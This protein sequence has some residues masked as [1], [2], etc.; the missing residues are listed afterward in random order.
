M[1]KWSTILFVL[2]LILTIGAAGPK[3]PK[4]KSMEKSTSTWNWA[5]ASWWI[6][7]EE[8]DAWAHFE[9]TAQGFWLS[10]YIERGYAVEEWLCYDDDNDEFDIYQ[11]HYVHVG[12][13]GTGEGDEPLTP[14]WGVIDW[15]KKL[16]AP[17]SAAA[18]YWAEVWYWNACTE[19]GSEEPVDVAE[20]WLRMDY[21]DTGPLMKSTTTWTDS[22]YRE[23]QTDQSRQAGGTFR[24]FVNEGLV[25]E[26]E[27]G[28]QYGTSKHTKS[29]MTSN[30]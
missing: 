1:R 30:P 18:G 9:D 23:T 8:R 7:E 28:G 10:F 3:G 27:A 12:Q 16:S 24:I 6:E 22:G 11:G 20:I 15:S 19:T 14:A 25:D 17:A 26:F 29:L 2:A 4:D 5:G 21:T 13:A